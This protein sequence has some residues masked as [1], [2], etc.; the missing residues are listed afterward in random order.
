MSN[1]Q[2][3]MYIFCHY[4]ENTE[5]IKSKSKFINI[6]C[7]SISSLNIFIHLITY[8][9]PKIP[10]IKDENAPIQIFELELRFIFN[11]AGRILNDFSLLVC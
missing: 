9:E 1:L 2:F 10:L 5:L 3:S 11:V 6:S 4:W 8:N 7:S